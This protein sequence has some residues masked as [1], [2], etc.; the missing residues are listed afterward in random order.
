MN[1]V[2]A[3]SNIGKIEEFK[4]YLGNNAVAYSQLI[5]S[6]EIDEVGCNKEASEVCPVQIIKILDK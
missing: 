2:L 4:L 5:D 3:T 1:I 6:F